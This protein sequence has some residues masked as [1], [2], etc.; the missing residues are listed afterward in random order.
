MP[1]G[2]L[3]QS[4]PHP[5]YAEVF[6]VQE[7]KSAKYPPRTFSNCA[8]SDGTLRLVFNFNSAG[9]KLTAKAI[10]QMKKPS[11]DVDLNNPRPPEEVVEWLTKYNIKVLNVAGNSE[12]THSGITGDACDYLERVLTLMGF[13]EA[14]K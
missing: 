13:K 12:R 4:G 3:N 10:Q 1:K 8:D 7:H 11:F 6:G 5:K 2:F 14:A 9:E